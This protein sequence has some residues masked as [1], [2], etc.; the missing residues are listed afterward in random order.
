[1]AR[2]MIYIGNITQQSINCI[3]PLQPIILLTYAGNTTDDAGMATN[4]YNQIVYQARIQ[5]VSDSLIFKM[6]LEFGY[7][8]RRFYILLDTVNTVNR[9]T[10]TTG[11]YFY[12]DNEYW[13][14]MRVEEEFKTNW[15]NYVAMQTNKIPGILL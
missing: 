1:M 8:Y 5:P 4:S 9:N 10:G 2:S 7:T 15:G 13:R 11:D 14:I 12:Y 6:N 3:N